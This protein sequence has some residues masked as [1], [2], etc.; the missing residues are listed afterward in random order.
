[1]GRPT[2]RMRFERGSLRLAAPATYPGC[3]AS[4]YRS[5]SFARWFSPFVNREEVQ[6]QLLRWIGRAIGLDVHRDFC[7]IAVCEEGVVRSAGRVKTTPE[8]LLVL[9]ESLLPT[10]R[11]ALEVTG[12]AWEVARIL[13]P[14]VDRVV[15]VSPEDT[16]IARAR[17]KTDKLDSR[18]LAR[19]L[20]GG[21]LDAV[22]M[23]DESCRVLR[24]R[25]ARRQQLVRS[26][27]R[28]KNEVH[29]VL[30]R[31]L[32]GK[33]PVTDL[34]GVKGRQWLA[35]RELP[36][37]ETETVQAAMR[38][39]SFLDDELVAVERLITREML[40]SHAA[41]RLMTVP[42]V[43]VIGAAT[44]LAAVGEIDRF[45]TSRQL[46]A[47]LGLD[48]KV[49]QSGEQPARSGRISKRGSSSAR[50]ALVEAAW[51]VVQQPGPLRA[52]YQR[53]RARIG[54]SKAIVA[55][56]RKLAALFWYMLTRGEDYA[57]QQPSLTAEKLRKLEIAAGAVNNQRP[58]GVWA[59]REKMRDAERK[60]GEQAQASYERMVRDW[61]AATPKKV[62]ASATP[63]AHQIRPS[64]GA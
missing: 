31:R 3:A 44:F 13:E 4:T 47:Y 38:Q 10:D 22:W 54:A 58:A 41:R 50:W 16:G 42:G 33:P 20:A 55:T 21:E 6:V 14:Y 36:V 43:N 52:F 56:A 61:K 12:G 34:F 59:T 62:G 1:M 25:L 15:V 57:H 35:A 49:R 23:P 53:L 17:A 45:G 46:V 63:G 9:A 11:V 39:I 24:R 8:A 32:Q 2:T 19:L 37:E 64:I 26:R 7:E 18:T 48:P 51:S 29:A 30:M 27:T 60:L 28:C 40:G 5:V